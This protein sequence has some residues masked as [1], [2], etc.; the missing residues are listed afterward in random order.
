MPEPLYEIWDNDSA[1]MI[2]PNLSEDDARDMVKECLDA[3]WTVD[4]L[5]LWTEPWPRAI[6]GQ[7]LHDWTSRGGDRDP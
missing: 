1:N 6:S 4:G 7:E 5:S 2:C 3:G